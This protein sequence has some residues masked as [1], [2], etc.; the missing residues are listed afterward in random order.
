MERLEETAEIQAI[1]FI[2]GNK[3]PFQKYPDTYG[4]GLIPQITLLTGNKLRKV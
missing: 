3:Y 1:Q 4:R 2:N